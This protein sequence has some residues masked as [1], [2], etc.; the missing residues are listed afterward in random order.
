MERFKERFVPLGQLVEIRFGL[1]SGCDAFFMPTDVTQAV[2]AEY[3]DDKA[4]RKAVGIPR[5]DVLQGLVRIIRD[6]AGTY[7]AIEPEFIRPE[8]H[9]L[10]KVDRPTVQAKDLD[11]VV[12]LV[13]PPLSAIKGRHAYK[14]IKHGETATYASTKSRPVPVPQRP[15]CAGR[16]PWYDLTKLVDP[17][18]AF[19]P[20]AQQYRHIIPANPE[21]LV[22]NHNLFDL[23]A[24]QLSEQEQTLLVAILNS[25][26]V[27]LFKTFYGRYAGTEGNLKT[28][29]I[30]VNLIEVPDPRKAPK[31]AARRVV[32]AFK[33]IC[34][35]NV[36]PLVE[37]HLR[38]CHTYQRALELAKRPVTMP[39][40]LTRSDRR[41]LDDAVFELLGVRAVEERSQWLRRL[42]ET[43][44]LHFRDVRVT[45]IQ[46]ME[47]RR[48]GGSV[49]FAIADQAAD[50]WDAL[51][52]ADLV[53]LVEWV[54]AQ[55]TG[56]CEV[57]NIPT[58]RPVHLARS[59]IFD[60]ETVYFGK[61][62]REYMVC[63]SRG[64]AELVA[65]MA[66]LGV[67][68]EASVPKAHEAAKRLRKLLDARHE[69]AAE[70]LRELAAS[71]SSDPNT[72]QEVFRLLERWFVLGKPAQ[73]AQVPNHVKY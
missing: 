63:Q 47:D 18:F 35:R 2:L 6:G 68:G 21:S 14:Y 36:G 5:K 24:P 55:T 46:K 60:N 52:L 13:P 12:V 45:E 57:V 26:L 4:F 25:T 20:M 54:A 71:R 53:P 32:K 19:W 34:E 61:A 58:D 29:V 66:E 33:T 62:R 51:D 22:C 69:A 38:E 42:Y 64:E 30:D 10:M 40:E 37:E 70:R 9:S 31:R 7:H 56:D 28:E 39:L 15:T 23:S 1:K 67:S 65:R 3:G 73:P 59:A 72:Q 16:D 17:G 50:A 11:R 27:G 43:T 44:V 48:S 41:E 49:R 8:V